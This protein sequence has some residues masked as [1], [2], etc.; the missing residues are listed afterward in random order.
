[1]VAVVSRS[2]YKFYRPGKPG[3]SR[4]WHRIQEALY[5][6][7]EAALLVVLILGVP[8]YVWLLAPR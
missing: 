2:Y 7:A 3:W 5:A 8:F 6:T 1:M 4:R